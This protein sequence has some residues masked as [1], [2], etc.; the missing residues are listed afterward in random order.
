MN[1]LQ[2]L[3][4]ASNPA[5]LENMTT[6]NRDVYF[7]GAAHQKITHSRRWRPRESSL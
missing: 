7:D 6:H 1:P 5:Y 4:V 3:A 2:T